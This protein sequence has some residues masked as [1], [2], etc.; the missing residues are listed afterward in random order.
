M[1]TYGA[2]KDALLNIPNENK[3]ISARE[4]VAWYNGLP[5]YENFNPDL[6]GDSAMLLGQGNVAVDVARILLSSV[7]QLAKT[8]IT[9]YALESLSRSNIKKVFLVGRRG[10][11][12]V[13]F[14]IKELRE[15]L[16]LPNV[17][18][19]WRPEDF[20]GNYY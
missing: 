3:T 4:F 7:D 10:P 12:Q 14:T 20:N 11:L 16:K 9:S 15:M 18:T 19:I 6:S 13:A 2:D 1:K 8:D 5:G 17:D